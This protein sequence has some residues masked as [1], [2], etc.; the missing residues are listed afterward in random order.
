[1]VAYIQG[2]SRCGKSETLKR[3]I[4]KFTGLPVPRCL[5]ALLLGNGKL[6]VYVEC[7][8]GDTPLGVAT[9][10]LSLFDDLKTSSGARGSA[11]KLAARDAIQRAMAISN[12][13]DVALLALEEY[14][15]LFLS[16]SPGAMNAAASMLITMQ[17]AA[18][19]P[20]M[21]TGSPRLGDLF[22]YVEAVNERAGPRVFLKPL[23]FLNAKDRTAFA[24]VVRQFE[25][26]LPFKD[27]PPLFTGDWLPETFFTT[28]GRLGRLNKLAHTATALAFDECS[29]GRHPPVLTHQHVAEAFDILHGD[30]E[31]MQGVNPWRQKKEL[32][33]HPRSVDEWNRITLEDKRKTRGARLL[34][35]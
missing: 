1:M 33:P 19:F 28:R 24:S 3:Y 23:P 35:E 2:Y 32:P 5:E 14:Q 6:V 10:I 8:F 34:D 21:V 27:N 20:I 11:A 9:R 31:L 16:S 22:A 29:P 30:D 18:S 4:E 15:N 17:D 25:K 13:N 7:S 12:D 26:M